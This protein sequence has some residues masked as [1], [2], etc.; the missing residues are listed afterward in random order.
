MARD[1]IADNHDVDRCAAKSVAGHFGGA[2]DSL[3]HFA[4][5][6][7]LLQIIVRDPVP[8]FLVSNDDEFPGLAVATR[9]RPARTIKDHANEFLWDVPAL[10]IPAD[11]S[12]LLD[13]RAK[14]GNIHLVLH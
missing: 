2:A 12:A 7:Q 4:F 6:F 3:I 8:D 13:Q 14:F 1:R 10:I 11:T 5:W 9:R